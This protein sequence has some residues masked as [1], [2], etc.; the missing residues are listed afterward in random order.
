MISLNIYI[1]KNNRLKYAI[2]NFKIDPTD[3][4]VTGYC[5]E[6]NGEALY[7]EPLK[8]DD[9]HKDKTVWTVNETVRRIN[10]SNNNGK[11]FK[12]PIL[13]IDYV[14]EI[15]LVC[16]K[17]EFNEWDEEDFDMDLFKQKLNEK[18]SMISTQESNKNKFIKFVKKTIDIK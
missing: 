15:N 3:I 9:K 10:E 18:F 13:F 7:F 16:S 11:V 8:F 17:I 1:D 12:N 4:V 14:D 5:K 2:E 6:W